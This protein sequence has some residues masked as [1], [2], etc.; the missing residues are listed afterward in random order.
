MAQWKKKQ[1]LAASG[2]N[3]YQWNKIHI[4]FRGASSGG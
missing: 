2:D 3:G 1:L 4:S